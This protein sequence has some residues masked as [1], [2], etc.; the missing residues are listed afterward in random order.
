MIRSRLGVAER[1]TL[2]H[3]VLEAVH[4]AHERQVIHRDLKP[5][6][7]LM[8]EAGE[9]RLLD[10]GV[11]KLLGRT[12]GAQLT[13]L[14]GCALTPDYASPEQFKGGE[15]DARSDVY[16][17]GVV[18]YELLTGRRPYEFNASA[19]M[20][21]LEQALA[22]VQIR[23]PST[24]LQEHA[25]ANRGTTQTKL[26]HA[27]RGDLDVIALKALAMNRPGA[28]RVRRPWHTT[29]RGICSTGRSRRV[30]R[31]SPT[32]SRSSCGAIGR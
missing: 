11:A 23:R 27:L 28:T 16:S 30:P 2:L 29:S 6:N 13:R 25:G 1:L 19:S 7:I 24:Q 20:A 5:S 8:S 15:L 32:G 10:F 4:Y 3:R 26:A 17:I 22:A 31:R 12:E 21:S 9:V 18:L 14:Y